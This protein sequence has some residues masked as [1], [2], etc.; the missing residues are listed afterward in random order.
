MIQLGELCIALTPTPSLFSMWSLRRQGK[1]QSRS[2]MCAKSEFEGTTMKQAKRKALEKAGWK[3]GDTAEF[4][5]LSEEEATYIEMKLRLAEKLRNL[6]QTQNVSQ[7]QLAKILG[8]SQSRVAK[9]EA[10]DPSV[11]ADLL[12]KGLLALGASR[13]Q[14]ARTIGTTRDAA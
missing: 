8:S 3:V 10:G 2:S 6:R 7:T 11:S 9:M 13:K 5:E 4:L 1:L 14:I 12:L